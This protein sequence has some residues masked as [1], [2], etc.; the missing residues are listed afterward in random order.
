MNGWWI[1]YESKSA[2]NKQI[3]LKQINMGVIFYPF[4]RGLASYVLPCSIFYRPGSG[5]TFS[6]EY[7]YCVWL[8]HLHYLIENK[9]FSSLEEIKNIA[10]IG[11]GDSLGI[12][13]SAI[14]TG[15]SNYC[16]FDVLEHANTEKNQFINSDL[17]EYFIAQKSIPNTE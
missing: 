15:A 11:P 2:K 17:K 6:S 16:A 12:G 3:N 1:W 14:Y 9:L 5:G 7:C 4:A 10:E 8:R 13:L